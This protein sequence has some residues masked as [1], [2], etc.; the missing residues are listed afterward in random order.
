MPERR[1]V[2]TLS[3]D[4]RRFIDDI[5]VPRDQFVQRLA[6]KLTEAGTG[7][8]SIRIDKTAEHNAVIKLLSAANQ[9]GAHRY[10][11]LP[12]AKTAR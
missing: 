7:M 1:P 12:A 6:D 2:V 11:L 4:G 5:E 8:V 9:A 3:N 10:R